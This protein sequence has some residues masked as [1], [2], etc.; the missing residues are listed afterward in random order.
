M[1][2]YRAYHIYAIGN[3]RSH[4]GSCSPHNVLQFWKRWSS[5]LWIAWN[6]SIETLTFFPVMHAV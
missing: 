1:Q 6:R 2:L 3:L 4:P 5:K